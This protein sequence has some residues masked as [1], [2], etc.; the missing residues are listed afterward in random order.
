MTRKRVGFVTVVQLGLDCLMEIHRLGG[1]IDLLITLDDE[2]AKKKSG[3]IFLDHYAALS[4]AK[5]HKTSHINNPETIEAIREASLDYLLVIGWS[6]LISDDIFPLVKNPPL[7]IHPTLLPEGRG[8]API[9]WTILKG[10]KRS[11]VTMFELRPEADSGDIIA[12]EKF[13]VAPDETATTLYAKACKAHVS[14]IRDI[15]PDLLA[16][17]LK[18]RAQDDSKATHWPQRRPTDG[19][20]TEELSLEEIDR[21]V[22]ATT[23]PY[24]GAFVIENGRKLV[25]WAGAI[26][27]LEGGEFTT[28]RL[29]RGERA[30][31]PTDFE[32]V[33]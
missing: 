10:L 17:T 16:G 23:H 8:R 4:G 33:S 13:N 3:R 12:V 21:L 29:E 24:P 28:P 11:G 7:G 9:P 27:R 25:I 5:L 15:W 26:Q 6:Q 14:L 1:P 32:W 19:E 18:G 30:F 2:T 22:R 31:V 20:I